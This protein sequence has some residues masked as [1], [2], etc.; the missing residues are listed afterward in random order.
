MGPDR[1]LSERLAIF[2]RAGPDLSG[3]L[4]HWD[5]DSSKAMPGRGAKDGVAAMYHGQKSV[6][7][8]ILCCHSRSRPPALP[9]SLSKLSS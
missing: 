2:G 7:W 9:I 6:S 4:Q 8:M 1:R 5:S 3:S